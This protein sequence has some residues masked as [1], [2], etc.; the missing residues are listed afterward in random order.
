MMPAKNSREKD[1]F[2][3]ICDD[4]YPIIMQENG[5]KYVNGIWRSAN[6][7][8]TTVCAGLVE[9]G[10]MKMSLEIK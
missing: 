10:Q 9:A 3:N 5:Y 4:C 6:S 7:H 1:A 2:R 8:P